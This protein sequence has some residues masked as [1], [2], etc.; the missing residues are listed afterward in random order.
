MAADDTILI[1]TPVKNG[2][3][4]LDTYFRGLNSLT[5]PK[6]LLSLGM[7]ESDST[8]GTYEQLAARL[9][10]M[11]GQFRAMH[12]FRRDFGFVI[13]PSMPRW[14]PQIQVTRRS[15]LAKARNQLLFRSLD[16]EKWV[17]WLDVDVIEYP[18][19]IITRLLATGKRIVT[20]N[21]VYTYGGRSFDLNSWRDHGRYH[22]HDLKSEGELVPLDAV[23]GTMLL[24][25]ADIHRDGV[26]FPPFCYGL[27]NPKVRRGQ[28]YWRGEI[29]T[30]GLGIM[31]GDAGVQCWG[32]PHL[33]IKHDPR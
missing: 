25:E 14:A 3:D 26:I 9:E 1:L 4:H 30:E 15:I 7:L 21:C 6:H 33:E 10:T 24:I 27:E 29:E 28:N 12:L 18:P 19:D 22:M 23:G 2:A 5:Y 8:D 31:A 32:M 11:H 16:D 17:L 13:P 20:P